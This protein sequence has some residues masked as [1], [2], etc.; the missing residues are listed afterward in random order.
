[1]IE[2]TLVVFLK[3]AT[4]WNSNRSDRAVDILKSQPNG[5]TSKEKSMTYLD[6]IDL[7]ALIIYFLLYIVF[8]IV[9]WIYN[10]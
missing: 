4:E 8:N 6:I 1:M 10:L 7:V 9:Y 2:L 3:R 5:N